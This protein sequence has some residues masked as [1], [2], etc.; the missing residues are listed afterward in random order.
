YAMDSQEKNFSSS[1]SNQDIQDNLA[2]QRS[3]NAKASAKSRARRRDREAHTLAESYDLAQFLE[4]NENINLE[5]SQQME[6]LKNA[7]LQ[8]QDQNNL[9]KASMDTI[10]SHLEMNL[11]IWKDLCPQA[12]WIDISRVIRDRL[13][14]DETVRQLA[15]E[16]AAL[17]GKID[18]INND[19]NSLKYSSEINRFRA[20][21]ED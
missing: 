7:N 4:D 18:K 1:S 11:D 16:L 15:L 13:V 12:P 17:Q 6:K 10:Q 5:L 3:K 19:T 21:D 14:M 9:L 20:N 8:L 2:Q